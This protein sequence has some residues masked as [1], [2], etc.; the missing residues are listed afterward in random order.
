MEK[1]RT[2]GITI[3]GILGIIR[4]IVLVFRITTALVKCYSTISKLPS[5]FG[6]LLGTIM[7]SS[8]SLQLAFGIVFLVAGVDVLK[9]KPRGH[10]L[11]LVIGSL[12]LLLTGISFLMF[13][14]FLEKH[15][16]LINIILGALILWFFNRDK[17][18]KSFALSEN[19]LKKEKRGYFAVIIVVV[20]A[21]LGYF[22]FVKFCLMPSNPFIFSDPQR[23]DYALEDRGRLPHEY[24]KRQF[25][26]YD[27]YLPSDFRLSSFSYDDDFNWVDMVISNPDK[28]SILLLTNQSLFELM[29]PISKVFGIDNS[30]EFGKRFVH[31]K[32][33]VIFLI[34][35]RLSTS[36]LGRFD[37]VYFGDW[38]GF[39]QR[40][41]IK[42]KEV[43]N[44]TI[45]H[46]D[47]KKSLGLTFFIKKG[48]LTKSEVES[49][50][51][52][53]TSDF[54]QMTAERHFQ[55]GLNLFN[56][57]KYEEAKFNF[58]NAIC[59]NRQNAQYYYYLGRAF[60]E[61]EDWSAAREHFKKAIS[62]RPDYTEAQRLL[63][64][65]ESKAKTKK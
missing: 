44:Y 12:L 64:E 60:F 18:K 52:S 48:S 4:G 28:T 47:A 54:P 2:V 23:I 20:L 56:Q 41:T 40:M 33:S 65:A 34:L 13:G 46:K 30:Y 24:K 63:D 1:K 50:I 59:Q 39:L 14:F 38:K 36:K 26:N 49:I 11:F 17:T 32:V 16:I 6:F 25:L 29:R 21:V 27:I 9:L 8:L 58:V 31:E 3:F 37:E 7:A 5:D 43:Y 61:T 42:D 62:L 53:V 15:T 55:E 35:R 19:H 45:W 51:S 57:N 10:R 22:Y